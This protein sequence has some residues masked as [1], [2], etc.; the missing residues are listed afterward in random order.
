M[1]NSFKTISLQQN[2]KFYLNFS[3]KRYV[4][5]FSGGEV[6]CHETGCHSSCRCC[7]QCTRCGMRCQSLTNAS[8]EPSSLK[9][10]QSSG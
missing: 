2:R 8:R 9:S 10:I 5:E 7:L 6:Y 3:K 1:E 4:E